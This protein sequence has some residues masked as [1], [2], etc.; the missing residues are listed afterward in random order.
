MGYLENLNYNKIT[1]FLHSRRYK[2]V[3]KKIY[4]RNRIINPQN[5]PIKIVDIGC[6]HCEVFKEL[7]K[8]NL[9]FEYLGIEPKEKLINIAKDNYS[10]NKRFNIVKGLADDLIEKLDKVDY[11]LALECLEHVPEKNVLD[12]ILKIK[13]K[14]T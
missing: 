9:N 14:K 1:K 8:T 6:G 12:I 13:K 10:N 7:I 4:L 11:F 2:W 5:N 3:I